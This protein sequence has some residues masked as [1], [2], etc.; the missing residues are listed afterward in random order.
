MTSKQELAKSGFQLAID[1]EEVADS[2]HIRS[3]EH[4]MLLYEAAIVEAKSHYLKEGTPVEPNL[5]TSLFAER[6]GGMIGV[7]SPKLMQRINTFHQ[8][9]KEF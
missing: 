2:Y 6:G 9:F 1:L 8:A 4:E 3:D 5:E 7:R